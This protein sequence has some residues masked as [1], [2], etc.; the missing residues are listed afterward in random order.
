[1]GV[2]S[3]PGN[4][5]GIY[6]KCRVGKDLDI[7]GREDIRHIQLHVSRYTLDGML[8]IRRHIGPSAA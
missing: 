8:K 4:F 7:Q 3:G 1:M 5:L 2:A 6:A